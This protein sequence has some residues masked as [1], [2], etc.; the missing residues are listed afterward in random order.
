[1]KNFSFYIKDNLLKLFDAFIEETQKGDPTKNIDSDEGGPDGYLFTKIFKE[2]DKVINSG[3]FEYG[4]GLMI[5]N[6]SSFEHT[7]VSKKELVQFFSNEKAII[8]SLNSSIEEI[9]E[10]R[11][12]LLERLRLLVKQNGQNT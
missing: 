9:I 10:Y 7:G 6:N 11:E 4:P 5:F 8:Q 1:M 12:L 3:H 2:V